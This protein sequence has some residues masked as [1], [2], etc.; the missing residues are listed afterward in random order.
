[1]SGTLAPLTEM[2]SWHAQGQLYLYWHISATRC[3]DTDP[4]ID[5]GSVTPQCQ[6]TNGRCLTPFSFL[7]FPLLNSPQCVRPS[8]LSMLH[9][10]TQTHHTQQDSSGRVISP[11]QRPLPDNTH[12]S[13]RGR[14][15][16]ITVIK[17]KCNSQSFSVI[18]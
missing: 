8:S 18:P 13:T 3:N 2:S 17:S 10:H 15:P 16:E 11:S 12:H 5:P 6:S 4:L 14:H 9:D 1:M 7:F